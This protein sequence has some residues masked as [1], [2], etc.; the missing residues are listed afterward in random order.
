MK[1]TVQIFSE[2]ESLT[3]TDF[4]PITGLYNLLKEAQLAVN[5]NFESD[6]GLLNLHVNLM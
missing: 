6:H 4:L 3:L 1:Q 2:C 5:L